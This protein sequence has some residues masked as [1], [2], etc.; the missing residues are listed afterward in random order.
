MCLYDVS[1]YWA[2]F[3]VSSNGM[4]C[5]HLVNPSPLYMITFDNKLKLY[6][7]SL[8]QYLVLFARILKQMYV[9]NKFSKSHRILGSYNAAVVKKRKKDI[10]SLV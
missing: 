7:T 10:N 3:H 8:V 6:L 5:V 1:S 2:F 9:V 4:S